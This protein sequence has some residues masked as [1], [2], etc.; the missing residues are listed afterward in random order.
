[1][2]LH[3]ICVGAI[4]IPLLLSLPSLGFVL[5]AGMISLELYSLFTPKRYSY[6]VPVTGSSWGDRIQKGA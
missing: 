4:S 1:M 2:D 6:L 3:A 5:G